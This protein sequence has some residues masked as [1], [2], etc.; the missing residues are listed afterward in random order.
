M[1]GIKRI[2]IV[3]MYHQSRNM[4][5]LLQAYALCFFL[6]RHGFAAKQL[7]L[8]AV[9]PEMAN[10]RRYRENLRA[11]VRK[12]PGWLYQKAMGIAFRALRKGLRARMD[13]SLQRI[14][15]FRKT[16]IPNDDG[17]VS[18]QTLA[19]C[20]DRYDAFICGSDQ[21]WNPY[22]Y[23]G[24]YFL[25]FADKSKIR[26]SYA[27][28]I[29]K[30]RIPQ[31]DLARIK[32]SLHNLSA[33][34]V[35]EETAKDL[36]QKAGIADVRVDLDPTMLLDVSHWRQA[37]VAPNIGG[38][39]MFYYILE[40]DAEKLKTAR[41]IA[42]RFRLRLVMIP[43][44]DDRVHARD[45]DKRHT[46]YTVNSPF[47]FIGLIRDAALVMTDSFHAT[48]FSCLFGKQFYC[49]E[50]LSTQTLLPRVRETLQMFGRLDSYV[51]HVS[52]LDIQ[53]LTPDAVDLP[54]AYQARKQRSQEYLLDGLKEHI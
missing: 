1:D 30:M 14:D 47:E 16:M 28:S 11:Y 10:I 51:D 35:R 33:V 45:F 52:R 46:Q 48:V 9:L 18:P 36:L 39:Y 13:E 4:G 19:Q 54:A 40:H 3:S 22:A 23:R 42:R 37:A 6:N 31:A 24:E 44:V 5:G 34:S 53:A 41:R 17:I 20:N 29:A 21:I 8:P 43:C 50:C 15:R 32:N 12:L 49:L 2:G 27:A 7:D 25:L 26:L 38:R